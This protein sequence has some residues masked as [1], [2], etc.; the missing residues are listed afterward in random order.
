[1]SSKNN[2]IV[3][4]KWLEQ[5]CLEYKKE[6]IQSQKKIHRLEQL[7]SERDSDY[8]MYNDQVDYDTRL[9][10]TSLD[11]NEDA[12]QKF[13]TI[14]SPRS[15]DDFHYKV[16][17]E[18]CKFFAIFIRTIKTHVD[19]LQVQQNQGPIFIQIRNIYHQNLRE[20][21]SNVGKRF[22]HLLALLE[23]TNWSSNLD[24]STMVIKQQLTTWLNNAGDILQKISEQVKLCEV[25]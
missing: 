6:N 17:S 22:D 8:H 14:A 20:K 19:F 4:Y 23:S 18:L 3:R 16:M 11:G 2:Y 21:I 12:Y 9:I 15:Y 24:E 5:K 1:M 13:I 10:K 7:F 25:N